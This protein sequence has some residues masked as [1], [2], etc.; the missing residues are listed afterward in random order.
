MPLKV[1]LYGPLADALGKHI[2][3]EVPEGCS[4]AELRQRLVRTHPDAAPE[5]DRSRAIVD[6]IAVRDDHRI[7][8]SDEVEFLPPVSG[9]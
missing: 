6:C 3:V 1:L 8:A 7:I 4:V 2:D 9:G 5:I